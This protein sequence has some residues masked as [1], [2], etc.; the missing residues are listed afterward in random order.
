MCVCV[1]VCPP[2]MALCVALLSFLTCSLS[3]STLIMSTYEQMCPIVYFPTTNNLFLFQLPNEDFT[4][5]FL[6]IYASKIS[7]N[8]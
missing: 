1:C 6:N 7:R 5:L 4:F 2:T 8:M 3:K